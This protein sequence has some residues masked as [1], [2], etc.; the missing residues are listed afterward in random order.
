MADAPPLPVPPALVRAFPPTLDGLLELARAHL[1]TP[2][3]MEM[4]R[5]DYGMQADEHFA[6]L[7]HIRETGQV[8]APIGWV[9]QEVLE[10]IR[11]SEPED[12]D[13]APGGQGQRGH[14]MR[15][16][17]CAALLRA[18]AEPAN[19]QILWGH[20]ST[21]AQLA[22]SAVALGPAWEEALAGFVTARLAAPGPADE[23]PF[24][25][26]ALLFLAVRLRAGRLDD[27]ALASAAEWAI[28]EEAAAA[29]AGWDG[30]PAPSGPWLL[31]LGTSD[32]R[33]AVWRSFAE[34]MMED[35]WALSPAARDPVQLVAEALLER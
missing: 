34:R 35:G 12:P 26:F 9:P 2:M 16:F 25:A 13:W 28:E 29:R 19:E 32:L 20:S 24:C 7:K 23:R 6:A 18:A 10:L 8:P 3:L 22:A 14:H 27:G 5:A 21:L 33:D 30:F 11:W 4:S 15:A 1:D 31:R 17:A